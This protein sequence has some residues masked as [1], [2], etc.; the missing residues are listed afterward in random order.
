MKAGTR[1]HRTNRATFW[2]FPLILD[3]TPDTYTTDVM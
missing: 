3:P 1:S 2:T